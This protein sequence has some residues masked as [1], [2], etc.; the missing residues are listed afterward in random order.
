MSALT[1]KARR[2]L[3]ALGHHL[4]PVVLV[5]KDGVSDGLLGAV[6]TAL[7]DH[8]LVKIKLGENAEGE[9]HALCDALAA[10]T[11]SEVVGVLGRTALLYKRHP[12]Q[13]K[14]L[15]TKKEAGAQ[16]RP[17]KAAPRAGS[18]RAGRKKPTR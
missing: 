14:L 1:P 9:R 16:K 13:P 5:G 18:P 10:G 7:A 3:R 4:R 8:E 12:K 2:Q 11:A 15:V 6:T 17:Q